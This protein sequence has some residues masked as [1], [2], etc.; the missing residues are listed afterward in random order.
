MIIFP[1][2]IDRYF[3]DFDYDA[4]KELYLLH[5]SILSSNPLPCVLNHYLNAKELMRSMHY[6]IH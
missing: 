5:N 6:P 4:E 1:F 3:L 2:S